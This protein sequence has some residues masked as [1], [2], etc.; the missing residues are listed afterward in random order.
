MVVQKGGSQKRIA[1]KKATGKHGAAKNVA[2]AKAVP[3]KTTFGTRAPKQ[4]V[5]S[6]SSTKATTR[7]SIPTGASAGKGAASGPD[8]AAPRSSNRSR[9]DKTIPKLEANKNP[10]R[11]QKTGVN[12]MSEDK[13]PTDPGSPQG[14]PEQASLE[15]VR[16]IL[17]G[18]QV[19]DTQ[20]RVDAL[21]T[22]LVTMINTLRK[23]MTT[24]HT[25]IDKSIAQL[26]KDLDVQ[27]SK[28]AAQID[29]RFKDTEATIAALDATAK[30]ARSDMLDQLS[31]DREALE[32]RVAGWNEDMA[33]EL[34]KAHSQLQHDK[35]DRTTLAE[36]LAS[37]AHAIANDPA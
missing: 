32:A 21:E 11:T 20:Q 28:V 5:I 23:D 37:M 35:A 24:E 29:A 19:R 22:R 3:A 2:V 33:R 12:A 14:T 17:F 16:D 26:K 6:S 7:T 4:A 18:A 27:A 25:R 1:Q 36:L 8:R 10:K 34:D 13:N 31:S 15:T 9:Q 30:T